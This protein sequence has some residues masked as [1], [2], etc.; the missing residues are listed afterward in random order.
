[1]YEISPDHDPNPWKMQVQQLLR[2]S[3][4]NFRASKLLSRS[5]RCGG[6][7]TTTSEA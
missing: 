6:S 5:P 1:M 7:T 4:W 3:S 2:T